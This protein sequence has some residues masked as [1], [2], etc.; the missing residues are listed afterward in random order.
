MSPVFCI[1]LTDGVI[2]MGRIKNKTT[3]DIF[4]EDPLILTK[5]MGNDGTMKLMFSRYDNFAEDEGVVEF[6]KGG[7]ISTYAVNDAT[8]EY[9][10]SYVEQYELIEAGADGDFPS[11]ENTPDAPPIKETI[12]SMLSNT[13]P[14]DV[15]KLRQ[16]TFRLVVDNTKDED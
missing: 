5:Y 15:D 12:G 9:Y 6:S 2:V 10:E 13:K 3:T 4:V 7:I 8:R 1:H 11:D 14:L 16:N